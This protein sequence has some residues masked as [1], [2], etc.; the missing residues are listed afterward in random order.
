M[1][2]THLHAHTTFSFLDGY[3]TP[4]QIARRIKELGQDACAITD[5]GNI[6]GHV[7]C[8]IAYKKEGIKPIF[9]CEFY[10]CDDMTV[11]E[12]KN[13]APSLRQ[14]GLPHITVLAKTQEGYGNL[15]KLSR[16]SYEVG[17]YT[18][19]RIDHRALIDNQE[20]LIVLSGCPTGYPT[21]MLNIPELGEQSMRNWLEYLK[22]NI[23]NYY[24]EIVPQPG[25]S[26]SMYAAPLLWNAAIALGIPPVITADAHFP[27]PEDYMSQDAMLA[28]GLRK[29]VD[30]PSRELKLPEYQYYCSADE[31]AERA[32]LVLPGL[33]RKLIEVA[34][35]NSHVISSS[36]DVEIKKAKAVSFH[37]AT[38]ENTSDKILWDWILNGLTA[39][40]SEGKIPSEK[41]AD[42][43]DRA[44]YEFSILRDKGFC[45]Y[46]LTIADLIKW[47]KGHDALIMTRGSAGG[48]LL[49]WLLNASETDPILYGLSFERFY[50]ATRPDPPDVDIDFEQSRRPEALEYIYNMYGIDKCSQI[51]ALSKLGPHGSIQDAASALGI[52]RKEF[53]AISE[54]IN[55]KDFDMESQLSKITDPRAIAVLQRYPR[56]KPLIC[57]MVGQYRHSSIHAAG[58]LV[59]SEPLDKVIGVLVVDGKPI[60]AVDKYG[61]ASLGFLK[62]DMLSVQALD[63]VSLA[64]KKAR[65]SIAWLY[66]LKPDDP[67]VFQTARNG[68]LTGVFQLDGSSASRALNEIS[69]DDFGDLVAASVLCRPGAIDSIP[70]YKRNKNNNVAFEEYLSSMHPIVADIVRPT[71]GV[72]MY[73]EQVMRIA[74]ELAGFEWK[75]VHRLRKDVANK[76]GLDPATG[77]KWRAEWGDK[78]ISGCIANGATEKDASFWWDSVQHHGGYSF[79][80]S[81]AVTYGVI[82]YWMLYLKT[83]YPSSFYEAYLT[84][85]KDDT[86]KK[87]LITE[88]K[89]MGGTVDLIDYIK[90]GKH[91]TSDGPMRLIGGY[92]DLKF[93]G[94]ISADKIVKKAPF[95]SHEKMLAALPKRTRTMLEAAPNSVSDLIDVAPW[96]PLDRIDDNDKAILAQYSLPTVSKLPEGVKFDG[97]I[98]VAGY[99]TSTDFSRDRIMITLEDPGKIVQARIPGQKVQ[100]IGGPFREISVGDFIVV[101]G[102]W[103]GDSLFMKQFGYL[104]KKN[105]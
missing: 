95:D 69:A 21:R 86:L 51:A 34:V 23:E 74:R 78:F 49:L 100:S 59:S 8:S 67:A 81:H 33:D 11:K 62:I 4:E 31:I 2:F 99:V 77:D 89:K 26:T 41:W 52:H 22:R 68:M 98:N 18:R 25:W 53:S 54:V 12:Y 1:N 92:A 57:G 85:E 91:F 90:S 104:R 97:D 70:I 103:S 42:Y 15:L 73:Q 17:F 71:Y 36:C 19:P 80:K 66:S 14:D 76:A 45:D 82:G 61:A 88:F 83:Y 24:V 28:V 75:D 55:D 13:H 105:G 60:A 102:W 84:L 64:A 96:F 20:G 40:Y 93:V 48:S 43:C 72:L 29:T 16:M 6:I 7:P 5:H 37:G 30:D 3:G 44:K 10:I 50:D 46:I 35:N 38:A 79:N 39:K 58:V 9:G 32:R 47:M 56:L 27:K 65:G 63:M 94:E 101:T 87:R